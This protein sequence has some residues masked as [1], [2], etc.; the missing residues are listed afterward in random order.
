MDALR[1][2]QLRG[3][4]AF[5]KDEATRLQEMVVMLAQGLDDARIRQLRIEI[6]VVGARIKR[7]TD[8]LTQ[9]DRHGSAA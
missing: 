6:R 4:L 3:E 1:C 9:S 7:L 5:A 2:L 8:E